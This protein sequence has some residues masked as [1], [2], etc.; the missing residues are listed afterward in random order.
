[1][2]LLQDYIQNGVAGMIYTKWRRHTKWPF[3]RYRLRTFCIRNQQMDTHWLNAG[4]ASEALEHHGIIESQQTQN[5]CITFIQRR[6]NVFDV[7]PTLYKCYT[8]VLCFAGMI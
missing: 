8:N 4:P 2:N 5:I 1:M 7:G 6:T 3:F